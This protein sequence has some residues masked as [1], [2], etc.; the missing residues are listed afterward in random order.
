MTHLQLLPRRRWR[1]G[2]RARQRGFARGGLGRLRAGWVS[3]LLLE[4][5][6]SAAQP[7]GP[8]ERT[9]ALRVFGAEATDAIDLGNGRRR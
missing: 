1:R 9:E 3:T 2:R 7:P 6:R 4:P 5:L 8:Q